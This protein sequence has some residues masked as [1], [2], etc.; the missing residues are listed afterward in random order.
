MTRPN[1]GK[2]SNNSAEGADDEFELEGLDEIESKYLVPD[3][4]YKLK[5]MD[6]EKTTSQAGNPMWVWNWT[7][8]E[9]EQAGKDFKMWTAITAGALW[10][11]QQVLAALGLHDGESPRVKFS[12]TDAIGRTC[13]GEFKQESYQGRPTSKI[14][15]VFPAE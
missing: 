2:P 9:G 12:K 11:M 4:V 10:K 8:I 14:D 5:L 6:I 15:R 3:G 1:L 13:M 7:I